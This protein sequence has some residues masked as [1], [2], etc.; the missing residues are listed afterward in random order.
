LPQPGPQF[1]FRVPLEMAEILLRFQ[2]GFLDQIGGPAFGPQ[3]GVQLALGEQ[4]QIAPAGLEGLTQGLPRP[5]TGRGQPLPGI[6]HFVYPL[7]PKTGEMCR[8]ISVSSIGLHAGRVKTF[9][10]RMSNSNP[11]K[12][13]FFGRRNPASVGLSRIGP[14][15]P[16]S[17]T[18]PSPP[19]LGKGQGGR[20]RPFGVDGFDSQSGRLHHVLA[21]RSARER[22]SSGGAPPVLCR[23]AACPRAARG[24]DIAV[25]WL[26]AARGRRP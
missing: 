26:H 12:T 16:P 1:F 10:G 4:E 7:S 6:G 19:F 2:E 21:Q 18:P 13:K 3:I 24:S 5:G 11:A 15:G 25:V 17:F 22:P 20:V 9:Y 23:S 8:S 14:F